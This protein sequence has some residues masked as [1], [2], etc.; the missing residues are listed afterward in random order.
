MRQLRHM[1]FLR[2]V[3]SD[4][5]LSR[6][7]NQEAAAHQPNEHRKRLRNKTIFVFQFSGRAGQSNEQEIV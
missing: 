6:H 7:L 2:L 3:S 5:A 4:S 1:L